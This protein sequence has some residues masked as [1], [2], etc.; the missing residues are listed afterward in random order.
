MQQVKYKPPTLGEVSCSIKGWLER[1]KEIREEL[2]Q[3][4]DVK[5]Y[6]VE[7]ENETYADIAKENYGDSFFYMALWFVN[8]DRTKRPNDLKAGDTI[9]LPSR[10][11][12]LK[13]SKD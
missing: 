4:K 12:I 8:E 6:A 7:N 5:S 10:S 11:E 1:A 3:D 9:R 2:W 13:F